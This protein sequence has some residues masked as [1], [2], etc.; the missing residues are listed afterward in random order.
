MIERAN[1]TTLE[2]YMQ[3]H[4]WGPLSISNISFR[5]SQRPGMLSRLCEMS[6]RQGGINRFGTP[7]EPSTR[8]T[9]SAETVW[10][11]DMPEDCGGAGA[12]GSIVGFQKILHAL[13]A[14]DE[15]LLGAEMRDELFRP[16]L[17]DTAQAHF[18]QLRKFKELNDIYGVTRD[19]RVGHALGGVV[20]LEDMEGR[21]RKGTLS[22][23]G[24][25][26]VYW[27][28]D[29]AAGMSGVYGSQVIPTGDPKSLALFWDFER[30]MYEKA[31]KAREETESIDGGLE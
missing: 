14:G 1:H 7:L 26:N 5:P 23:Q 20:M 27:W 2:D 15:R 11:A 4:I 10:D 8:V 6:E 21:R 25:P 12:Y 22:W 9:A 31:E 24:M 19:D 18:S 13:A 29:R 30:A 28:V 16:Q 17:S 3:Q